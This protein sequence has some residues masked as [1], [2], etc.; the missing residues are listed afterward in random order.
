[1]REFLILNRY[2]FKNLNEFYFEWKLLLNGNQISKGRIEEF[3]LAPYKSK[4]IK[5]DIPKINELGEYYL[6]IYAKKKLNRQSLRKSD[7]P[8]RARSPEFSS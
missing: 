8:P 3:D 1:M 2:D 5:I 4:L 6:N 7:E